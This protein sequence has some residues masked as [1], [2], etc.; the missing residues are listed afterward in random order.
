MDEGAGP[1]SESERGGSAGREEAILW[2]LSLSIEVVD[3]RL[4]RDPKRLPPRFSLEWEAPV[5]FVAV[6]GVVGGRASKAPLAAE[7]DPL[8][9]LENGTGAKDEGG[10]F[11]A[12]LFTRGAKLGVV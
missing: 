3:L 8:P 10:G 1:A 7:I 4:K 9:D 12:R 6:D 5:P 11:A 2:L